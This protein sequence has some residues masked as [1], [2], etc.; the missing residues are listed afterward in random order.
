MADLPLTS[1][2]NPHQQTACLAQ[3]QERV[4][5]TGQE[6]TEPCPVPVVVVCRR[7]N[8]SQIAVECL[9]DKLSGA[10]VKVVD[11]QGGLHAW[12]RQV[13]PDFPTY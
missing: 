2:Q 1:L 10:D 11:I 12:T 6:M 4:G 3:L 8:D 13:D 5:A 7:G 9:Q